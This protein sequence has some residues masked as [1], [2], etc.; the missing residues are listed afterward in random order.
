VAGYDKENTRAAGI[1]L[2]NY[3]DNADK[4]KGTSVVVKGIESGGITVIP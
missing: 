4:L 2:K 3:K 1:V